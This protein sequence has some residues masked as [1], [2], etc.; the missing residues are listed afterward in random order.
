M[1]CWSSFCCVHRRAESIAVVSTVFLL[2]YLVCTAF[3]HAN[4]RVIPAGSD[5]G[6]ERL[7]Y[8]D[9]S[10]GEPFSDIPW[11]G[12]GIDGLK[13]ALMRDGYLPLI[14]R[15]F[16]EERLSEAGSLVFIGPRKPL[17]GNE[18]ATLRKFIEKGGT[19]ICMV[20]AEDAAGIGETLKDDYGILVA[21]TPVPPGDTRHEPDPT[22]SSFTPYL[23]L[24][25][26]RYAQM[27]LHAG[28]PIKG[29]HSDVMTIAGGQN[30][31][32]VAVA[33]PIGKGRI[34][35][36]ADTKFAFNQNLE[37]ASGEPLYGNRA[38]HPFL[39]LVVRPICRPAELDAAGDA[40]AAGIGRG[41]PR[42]RR[43]RRRKTRR[44]RASHDDPHVDRRGPPGRIVAF[45]TSLLRPG[46]AAALGTVC[47]TRYAVASG[48]V[49][50]LVLAVP[51]LSFIGFAPR[52][53]LLLPLSG[54]ER[55]FAAGTGRRGSD[56]K[57]TRTQGGRRYVPSGRDGPAGTVDRGGT[58]DRFRCTVTRAAVDPLRP[59]HVLGQRS[60][61]RCGP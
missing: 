9:A 38:N 33:R 39:A 30:G 44:G 13:L 6:R 45:R 55:S 20:G 25:N 18:R 41:G 15:D 28:W 50:R 19:V 37:T 53:T 17:T 31:E 1:P 48:N 46:G 60:R 14:L 27:L 57:R 43:V 49:P 3:V 52:S 11:I 24:E 59:R 21:E 12:E 61:C 54:K 56:W 42:A 2:C 23:E 4:T 40:D 26:K 29:L 10:H 35:V 51:G 5:Q 58:L 32:P 16:S 34:I 36:I 7:A 47:R 22:G 8:I